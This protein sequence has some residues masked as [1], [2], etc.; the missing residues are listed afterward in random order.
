MV[1]KKSNIFIAGHKGLVGG[2][3]YN[4]LKKSGYKNLIIVDKKKLDLTNE[5]KV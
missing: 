1:N 4:R 3:I 5:K 2:S